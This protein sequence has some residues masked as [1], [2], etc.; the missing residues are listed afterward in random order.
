ML[1]P[2]FLDRTLLRKAARIFLGGVPRRLLE[3]HLGLLEELRDL[4][5]IP[6]GV[7]SRPRISRISRIS[8]PSFRAARRERPP[9]HGSGNQHLA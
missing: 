4:V 8:S 5:V 9:G 7:A 1:M 2:Q 3:G 6:A